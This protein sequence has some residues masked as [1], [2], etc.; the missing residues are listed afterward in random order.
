MTIGDT[1]STTNPH[2]KMSGFQ[3]RQNP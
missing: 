1:A 3:T 2:L